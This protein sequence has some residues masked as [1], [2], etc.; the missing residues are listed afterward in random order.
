MIIK[1][2]IDILEYSFS[3][4]IL[5]ISILIS[6]IDFQFGYTMMKHYTLYSLI[7]LIL[8]SWK[9]N[10]IF[11][12]YSLFLDFSLFFVFSRVF[13][14]LI[15]Y[16]PLTNFLF[17]QKKV[18]SETIIFTLLCKLN[19]FLILIDMGFYF[20]KVH[21]LKEVP[22]LNNPNV[23][24]ISFFLFILTALW[25]SYKAFL[26]IKSVMPFGYSA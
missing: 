3:F 8:R 23:R 12:L 22:L 10:G 21:K 9:R 11:S 2:N 18:F 16:I 15:N 19:I 25:F 13:F 7:F 1:K 6:E 24:K 5:I 17:F 26:D 14:D 20:S 4:F